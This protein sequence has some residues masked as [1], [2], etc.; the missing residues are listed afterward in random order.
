MRFRVGLFPPGWLGRGFQLLALALHAE[1]V[2]GLTVEY[3]EFDSVDDFMRLVEAGYELAKGL[4]G[5]GCV[6]QPLLSPNDAR[7][8]GR[9]LFGGVKVT[10]W[11]DVLERIY[12]GVRSGAVGLDKPVKAPALLKANVFE[13]VRGGGSVSAKL[14]RG[15][16]VETDVAGLLLAMIGGLLSKVGVVR[17]QG[18]V[19]T[20]VY[21]IPGPEAALQDLVDIAPLYAILV[22][23]GESSPPLGRLLSA[24]GLR[25]LPLSLDVLA[26]MY[27]ASL[28]AE[29][30][31]AAGSPSVCGELR[32]NAFNLLTASEGGNRPILV[33]LA[34]LAFSEPLCMLT[35]E[36]LR[37]LA[38]LLYDSV[39]GRGLCVQ[40]RGGGQQRDA[41]A[42]AVA[43]CVE[44]LY[45]YSMTGNDVFVYDCAR[46]LASAASSPE[47]RRAGPRLRS[48]TRSLSTMPGLGRR[49]VPLA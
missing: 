14:S 15:P 32:L 26:T 9:R 18:R 8:L 47:C 40:G 38:S 39:T 23:R 3:A 37:K 30:L 31:E 33:Q 41:G 45:L 4:L 21:M 34:P 46:V 49:P 17:G 24:P 25:Q 2:R 42:D 10:R 20:A 48:L 36:V 5:E 13:Y 12:K 11:V 16:A 6:K 43:E 19:A 27:G 7:A 22:I 35:V 29:A 28:L 1:L 44:K